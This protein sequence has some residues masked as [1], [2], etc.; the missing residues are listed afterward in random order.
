[1]WSFDC[2][3]R[4]KRKMA[5]AGYVKPG[6]RVGSFT[7]PHCNCYSQQEWRYIYRSGGMEQDTE[8][9]TSWCLRCNK[10]CFWESQK[11][12]WPLKSGL[13][14]PINGCP[15]QIEA[16]YNEARQVF[17]YSP[18]ASAALLR[19]A[20]QMICKEKGLPGKDL[21]ADIGAL[22]GKG[23]AAEIQQSL[24][25][26]RV[27]GNHAVHPGHIVIEDNKDHI[28][29]F[30]G[31]VN[32]IVDVLIVQPARVSEMFNAL[33]PAVQQKQIAARDGKP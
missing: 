18:R 13:S 19:L 8:W 33:V 24:D 10:Y 2:L 15:K 31:L 27:V 22:V 25:L 9:T 11:L 6:F 30:F 17:P 29:K 1:A 28:E 26:V 4:Q 21:N 16:I 14:D 7:C 23:L 12:V 32:L 5:I 20:I 3:G